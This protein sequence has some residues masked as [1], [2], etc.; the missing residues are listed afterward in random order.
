MAK[1]KQLKSVLK[2]DGQDHMVTVFEWG[3]HTLPA[4]EL[5]QLKSDFIE[6][7]NYLQQFIDNNTLKVT[8]IEE[9]INT[10]YGGKIIIIVGYE[11]ETPPDFVNHE[12]FDY[13]ENRM[14]SDPNVTFN[15]RVPI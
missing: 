5:E 13:W 14:R 15:P 6:I 12:K 4:V 3:L 8:P 2:I 9:T 1:F 11:S 7:E 10:A